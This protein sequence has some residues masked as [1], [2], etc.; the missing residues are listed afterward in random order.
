MNN[1]IIY[2]TFGKRLLDIFLSCIAIICL[3]PVYVVIAVLIGKKLG[4]PILFKQ[5]RPGLYGNIFRMY[6]FRTMSDKRDINGELLPDRERLTGFGLLLR[7]TSLDE[8]P[9]LF[10]VLKGDM[11]LIGPRPLLVK[12]L[13]Y[14]TPEENER[15][16]VRPGLTGL[17]QVHGRNTC[18]WEER[19]HYDC[20]YVKNLSLK[21]DLWIIWMT[22]KKVWKSSDIVAPGVME[23]FDEYREK[24][25]KNANL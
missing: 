7:K 19:F 11:S 2:R 6:K 23:D 1:H 20:E 4:R 12:Y 8:L 24:Q 25:Y 21:M 15:H 5:D 9:E 3:S 18:V 22:I 17:A 10:N 14:Y 16:N 13:P